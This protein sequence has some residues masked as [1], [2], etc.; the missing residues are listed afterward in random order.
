MNIAKQGYETYQKSQD[1]VNET[2]QQQQQQGG[3]ACLRDTQPDGR[4]D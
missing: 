4:S 1:N 2:G 3:G